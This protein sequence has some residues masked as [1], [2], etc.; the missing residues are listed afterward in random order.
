M[1]SVADRAVE[2]PGLLR[3]KI[4]AAYCGH[5]L[6]HWQRKD[7]ERAIPAA[8]PVNGLKLWRKTDLDRW[9]DLGCPDRELFQSHQNMRKAS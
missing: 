6:R 2:T 5:S 7:A 3:A 9:I 8:I 1:T 4:A